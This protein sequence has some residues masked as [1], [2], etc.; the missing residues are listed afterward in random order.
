[1]LFNR[2]K[3][4]IYDNEQEAVRDGQSVPSVA[5]LRRRMHQQIM[6]IMVSVLVAGM[7]TGAFLSRAWFASNKKVESANSSITSDTP[8]PSLYIRPS[9]EKAQA[10]EDKKY[11]ESVTRN[12]EAALY[13]IST[14]DLTNWFYASSFRLGGYTIDAS[15]STTTTTVDISAPL[16]DDFTKITTGGGIELDSTGVSG[17]YTNAFENQQR[18]AYYY[19]C[20]NL[21]TES[22]DLDIYLNP[23]AP[24]TVTL[25]TSG[26]SSGKDSFKKAVRVGIKSGDVLLI[27][28]PVAET[29]SGNTDGDAD[30]NYKAIVEETTAGSSATWKL[31]SPAITVGDAGLADY[32]GKKSSGSEHIYEAGTT[33]LCTAT[34]AGVDVE[35]YVWLEGTD[36]AAM[37]GMSDSDDIGLSVKVSYVGVVPTTTGGD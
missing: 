37:V 36:S 34:T 16:A 6:L 9:S 21:Y 14:N 10:D 2:D 33:K 3:N 4:R 26:T 25:N 27:Y 28:A 23:D 24:I 12:I 20:D 30:T 31:E 7:S 13:P 18:T 35:V 19:T 15:G 1:M 29:E 17:V 22:G 11:A 8:S 5:Q 32:E